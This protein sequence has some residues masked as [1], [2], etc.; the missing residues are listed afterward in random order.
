MLPPLDLPDLDRPWPWAAAPSASWGSLVEAA[1]PASA[2]V[3]PSDG[4]TLFDVEQAW[5]RF[6]PAVA[7]AG[8]EDLT[9]DDAPAGRP[10]G[11][12]GGHRPTRP[13]PRPR[14]AA[15]GTFSRVPTT[16]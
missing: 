13:Q 14:M 11:V 1:F 3:L 15:T 7:L 5:L 6:L 10:L 2:A 12:A 16:S 8:P 9:A 4:V